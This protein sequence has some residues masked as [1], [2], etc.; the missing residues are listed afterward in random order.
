MLV[1][2]F[3]LF[4]F[5]PVSG[6]LAV[7]WIESP[8]TP[9]KNIALCGKLLQKAVLLKYHTDPFSGNSLDFTILGLQSSGQNA[10]QCRFTAAGFAQSPIPNPQSPIDGDFSPKNDEMIDKPE[11]E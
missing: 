8:V 4:G 2:V 6:I 1:Y 11:I 3:S 7:Q 5:L 9:Q 10:K